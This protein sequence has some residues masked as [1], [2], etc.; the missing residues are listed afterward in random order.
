MLPE[1]V[2]GTQVTEQILWFHV[3]SHGALGP[4]RISENNEI[5]TNNIR[6]YQ[7]RCHQDIFSCA[8]SFSVHKYNQKSLGDAQAK[9]CRNPQHHHRF[10]QI[11]PMWNSAQDWRF[12]ASEGPENQTP[13]QS[14]SRSVVLQ[15]AQI[16]PGEQLLERGMGPKHASKKMKSKRNVS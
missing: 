12:W 6:M 8:K 9:T 4:S 11:T 10:L 5:S 7:P 15:Q 1:H 13:P 2:L 16:P 3:T 14:S